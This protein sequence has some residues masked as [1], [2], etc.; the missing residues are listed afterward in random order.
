ML[1]CE[2]RKE[3]KCRKWLQNVGKLKNSENTLCYQKL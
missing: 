2:M 1:C 3:K